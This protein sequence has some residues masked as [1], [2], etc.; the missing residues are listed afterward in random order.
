MKPTLFIA[1]AQPE[2]A[3][4]FYRDTLG[5]TFLADEEFALVFDLHGTPLRVQKV[6]SFS[7]QP[8]TVLGWA[9]DDLGRTL[10]A[11]GLAPERFPWMAH[12]PRGVWTASSGDRVAWVKDPDGNLLSFTQ[13][14]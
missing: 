4:G 9:V 10:E 7:P 3:L 14:A 5:L 11:L 1:T 6:A 12:D 13:F 2:R 8:F